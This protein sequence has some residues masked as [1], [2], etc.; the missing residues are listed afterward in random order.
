MYRALFFEPCFC[1][2][3]Y[4]LPP[5]KYRWD[6]W[7]WWDCLWRRRFGAVVTLAQVGQ[8]GHHVA[9]AFRGDFSTRFLA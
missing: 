7:D 5:M 2:P 4:A 9:Q 1:P 6:W 8:V 3:P